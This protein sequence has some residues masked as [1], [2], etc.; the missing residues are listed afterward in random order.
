MLA[1][2]NRNFIM[3]GARTFESVLRWVL[4]VFFLLALFGNDVEHFWDD[5]GVATVG[6]PDGNIATGV[7]IQIITHQGGF[8]FVQRGKDPMSLY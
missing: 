3:G 2:K 7:S 4:P 8:A 5:G 6:Q 1:G